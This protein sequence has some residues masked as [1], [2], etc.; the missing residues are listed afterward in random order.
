MDRLDSLRAFVLV[1]Q[2]G[3]FSRAARRMAVSPAMVTK[4]IAALEARLGARLLHRTTRQVSVTE[5]GATYYQRC[6][7]LLAGLDEA[8]AALDTAARVPRGNL[9]ITASVDLGETHLPSILFDFMRAHP[10]VEPEL[11]LTNRFVDLVEEKFDLALRVTTKIPASSLVAR[12]LARSRL[13][14]VA[15]PAYL[16]RHGAPAELDELA[17]HRVVSFAHPR[18]ANEWPFE[19]GGVRRLV[20]VATVLKADSNAVLRAA[21]LDGV[22]LALQPSYNVSREIADGR[23]QI[24][25]PDYRIGALTLHAVYPH[26]RQLPAKVRV[27]VD[28]LAARFGGDGTRDPW[29]AALE[30]A[31]A[32]RR[33]PTRRRA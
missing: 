30:A 31:L 10:G 2:S 6:V 17:R 14:L 33:E 11:V 4:H 1:V 12:P 20:R 8:E 29:W 19:R 18:Y 22:G 28:F 26:R 32:A 27:F 13:V 24:V 3:G 23:L 5:A 21:A 15:A 16:A 9:R 25:L 7:E